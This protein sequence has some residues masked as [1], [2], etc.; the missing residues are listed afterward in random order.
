VVGLAGVPA[1][2]LK[3][4]DWDYVFLEGRCPAGL[5]PPNW[6]CWN[7]CVLNRGVC[8]LVDA[9]AMFPNDQEG[10]CGGLAGLPAAELKDEDWD[11]LFLEGPPPSGASPAKLDLLKRMRAEF[12]YWYPF[13]LRVTALLPP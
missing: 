9:F 5:L 12:Q 8:L 7:A 1:A 6:I 2:E 4:E 11:Y 3:D 13:D 10:E